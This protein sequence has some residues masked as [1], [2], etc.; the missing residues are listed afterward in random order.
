MASFPAALPDWL[1]AFVLLGAAHSA[2]WAAG[3]LLGQRLSAPIDAG[4]TLADGRRLLGAHKTWRGLAAAVLACALAAVLVGYT[5]TLGVTFAVLALA[6]DAASSLIKR[7]LRLRPG[8]EFPGLD[9]IPEALTPLLVL[10]APLRIDVGAVWTLTGVFMLA[11][12]AA[13]PLRHH[14]PP[15]DASTRPSEPNPPE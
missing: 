2:P 9:Q 4:M 15:R 6:G 8:T 11:D 10:S 3:Y 7:R 5:V 13:M 14:P 1:K 12:L